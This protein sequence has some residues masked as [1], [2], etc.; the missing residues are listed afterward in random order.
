MATSAERMR[1]PRERQRRGIR[2]PGRSSN[3]KRAS[4]LPSRNTGWQGPAFGMLT[5][6]MPQWPR[7]K[8]LTPTDRSRIPNGCRWIMPP[9][10]GADHYGND[11]SGTYAG[12]S[13][14]DH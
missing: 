6:M 1:A 8:P 14:T 4:G 10:A 7:R 3:P 2:S 9:S 12:A 13:E 11:G 5:S